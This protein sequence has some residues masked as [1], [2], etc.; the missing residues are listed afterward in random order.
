MKKTRK[1]VNK[2]LFN[3]VFNC[4]CSLSRPTFHCLFIYSIK[5]EPT[6]LKWSLTIFES[7]KDR[8]ITHVKTKEKG[9]MR[10]LLP[11]LLEAIGAVR[12]HSF[13]LRL[14]REGGPGSKKQVWLII[15]VQ[16][17]IELL[18]FTESQNLRF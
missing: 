7:R 17:V 1:C 11:Y 6:Q 16:P 13:K 14:R 2:S 18:L 9:E 15:K 3:S 4:L 12:G 8:S 5:S 10:S